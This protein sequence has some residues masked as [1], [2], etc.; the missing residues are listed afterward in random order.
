MK[1]TR[2]LLLVLMVALLGLVSRTH[3]DAAPCPDC[4]CIQ[5]CETR[6]S[7]CDKG[8]N[9]NQSCLTACGN[10]F[11]NCLDGCLD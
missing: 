5:G 8:C 2:V 9:G 10:Q 3:A 4:L 7:N 11:T 6:E 1:R